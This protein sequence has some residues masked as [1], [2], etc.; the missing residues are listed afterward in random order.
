[1]EDENKAKTLAQ[2]WAQEHPDFKD[3]EIHLTEYSGYW[4]ASFR[5]Q[6]AERPNI[7]GSVLLIDVSNGNVRQFSSSKGPDQYIAEYE[8]EQS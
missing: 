4:W 6:G 3:M 8:A 1:V 5:P 7:G 2:S